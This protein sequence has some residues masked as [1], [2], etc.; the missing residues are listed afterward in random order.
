M[1]TP[2]TGN[3]AMAKAIAAAHPIA[4]LG[5]AEDVAA[6]AAFLLSDAAGW[7]TGQVLGVDGGRAGL[8]LR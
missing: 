7:I 4:R 3:E 8:R 1:A 6:A 5:E 2:L